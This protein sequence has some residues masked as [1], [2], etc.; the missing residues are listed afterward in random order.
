MTIVRVL[1][2]A[3]VLL[4]A[5]VPAGAQIIAVAPVD[6]PRW[7]AAGHTGWTG[8]NK[9][10]VGAAW[11]DWYEAWSGGAT[12]GYYFTP[13]L[14]GELQALFAQRARVLGQ[15]YI[16][17]PGLGFP[18]IQAREHHFTA[19]SVSAGGVYQ[20]GRNQWF[21]PFVTGGVDVMR[22]PDVSFPAFKRIRSGMAILPT[23]CRGANK[24]TNSTYSSSRSSWSA[25]VLVI[26]RAYRDIRSR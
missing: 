15:E 13:H 11:D 12:G 1:L 14:K 8:G 22:E 6:Q 2:A 5:G 18:A 4:M 9:N 3:L 7:D 10:G 23:S 16:A 17:V 24:N 25:K 20:F 19:S 26:S 21:H